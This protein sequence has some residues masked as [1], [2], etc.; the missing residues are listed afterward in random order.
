M[1]RTEREE[2]LISVGHPVA[3]ELGRLKRLFEIAKAFAKDNGKTKVI[4]SVERVSEPAVNLFLLQKQ[5]N[6]WTPR[7]ITRGGKLTNVE[8]N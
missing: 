7:L 5:N 1:S 6:G 8:F 4:I 2:F 3:R